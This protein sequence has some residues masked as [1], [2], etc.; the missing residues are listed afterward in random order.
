MKRSVSFFASLLLL[1][2]CFVSCGDSRQPI[3][4]PQPLVGGYRVENAVAGTL[5]ERAKTAFDEATADLDGVGYTPL[6]CLGEKEDAQFLILAKA[7][8]VAPGAA[9]RLAVLVLSDAP[10]VSSVVDFPLLSYLTG[11]VDTTIA[12]LD[13]FRIPEEG[14]LTAMPQRLATAASD[15]LGKFTDLRLEA[16]ACAGEQ[17]VAGT[18]YALICRGTNAAGE[19]GLFVAVVYADLKGGARVTAV[20]PLDLSAF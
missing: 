7:Q 11:S 2:C 8:T 10:A 18:N 9:A 13:G 14:G 1:S 3:S 15:A 5:P 4:G 20:T 17:V 6:A 16:L 12:A 19:T